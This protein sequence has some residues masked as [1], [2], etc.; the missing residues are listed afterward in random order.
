MDN[1]TLAFI[2]EIF[3]RRNYKRVWFN[4]EQSP[5]GLGR[6]TRYGSFLVGVLAIIGGLLRVLSLG[7]YS[8]VGDIIFSM[9]HGL[10]KNKKEVQYESTDSI[11]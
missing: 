5:N 10:F 7:R 11:H 8:F 4:G 3:S 6:W 2:S 1:R 9:Q